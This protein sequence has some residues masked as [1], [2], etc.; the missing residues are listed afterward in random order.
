MALI[1]CPECGKEISDKAKCCIHCGYPLDEFHTTKEENISTQAKDNKYVQLLDDLEKEF[2]IFVAQTHPLNNTFESFVVK[3]KK[4]INQIKDILRKN[5]DSK[6]EDV[7]MKKF[8]DMIIEAYEWTNWSSIKQL[9]EII[10]FSLITEET[11]NY[12]TNVIYKAISTPDEF[13]CYEDVL[14]SYPIYQILSF[15]AEKNKQKL[16]HHLRKVHPG[17]TTTG[18]E[19]SFNASIASLYVETL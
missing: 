16:L 9:L 8:L 3:H 17:L 1:N 4:I 13:G 15:G 12:T 19:K 7:V 14:Y 11:M 6:S 2:K 5:C 10:D 18:Y